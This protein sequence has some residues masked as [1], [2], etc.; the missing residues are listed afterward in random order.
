MSKYIPYTLLLI[1]TS[2]TLYAQTTTV[3]STL[4]FGFGM[5]LLMFGLYSISKK[6]PNRTEKNEK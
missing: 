1:G 6:I 5:A 3:T 4:L 2:L